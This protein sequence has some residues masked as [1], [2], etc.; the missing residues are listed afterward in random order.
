MNIQVTRI[1][2]IRIGGTDKVALDTTL[3]NGV[4]PY[5][6]IATIYLDLASGSA[7]KYLADNFPDEK[8]EVV[9]T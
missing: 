1:V 2:V 9:G 8:F 3:P 7:E 4:W 6:G 5:D